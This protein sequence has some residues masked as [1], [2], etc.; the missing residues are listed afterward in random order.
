MGSRNRDRNRKRVT[1]T[2][3]GSP[4]DTDARR[5]HVCT[6]LIQNGDLLLLARPR[7]PVSWPVICT[8]WRPRAAVR[9]AASKR[10]AAAIGGAIA[11]LG[12]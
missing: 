6:Y 3:I 9:A 2:G 12:S 11:T 1:G 8:N 4:T 5:I 10:T 7:L